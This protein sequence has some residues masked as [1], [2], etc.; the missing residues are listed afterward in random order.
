MGGGDGGMSSGFHSKACP[1]GESAALCRMSSGWGS[2]SRISKAPRSHHKTQK[3]E[4]MNIIITSSKRLSLI[5]Q[6]QV[7]SRHILS[8]HSALIPQNTP[9]LIFF[10]FDNG[11]STLFSHCK[12][13]NLFILLIYLP[14]VFKSEIHV[15]I[16]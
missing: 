1:P 14:S 15:N 9:S 10:Y 4:N 8:Q 5:S 11:L 16:L 3:M 7:I 13:K 2:L 12:N 6:G